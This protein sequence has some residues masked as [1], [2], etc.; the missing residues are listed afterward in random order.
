MPLFFHLSTGITASRKTWRL[1]TWKWE[2]TS[3]QLLLGRAG[4]ADLGTIRRVRD[5]K[6]PT[7]PPSHSHL[8][9]D[10]K[11]K[12]KVRKRDCSWPRR[13]R[14]LT[15]P[16]T[17]RLT[18]PPRKLSL[19]HLTYRRPNLKF[20]SCYL[21]LCTLLSISLIL[22]RWVCRSL[23]LITPRHRQ[24]CTID[25]SA[26]SVGVPELCIIS[27]FIS[28]YSLQLGAMT[29]CVDGYRTTAFSAR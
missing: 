8:H 25:I 27:S 5:G 12:A 10:F 23:Q 11:T 1:K 22:P 2:L 17:P 15:F 13:P 6:T 20:A 3:A 29:H 21:S 4:S 9:P 28:L 19:I 7:R 18:S 16:P 24:T 26:K 14:N